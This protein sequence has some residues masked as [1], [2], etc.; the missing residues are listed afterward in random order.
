MGEAEQ[1]HRLLK[2]AG[3]EERCALCGRTQELEVDHID[4]HH[5]NNDL[6]NLRYL[7]RPCHLARHYPNRKWEP[8]DF[9]PCPLCGKLALCGW[10]VV[11]GQ[12]TCPK[13]F[14]QDF[15][16]AHGVTGALP[17]ELLYEYSLDYMCFI[18]ST[19]RH[20]RKK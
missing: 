12:Y 2:E 4:D 3:I 20:K 10:S 14:R 6:D 1:L 11:S 18:N 8:E 17:K 15:K 13:C 19:P 16:K 7:C 9:S 5:W